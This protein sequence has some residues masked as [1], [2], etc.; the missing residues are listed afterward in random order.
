MA[1]PRMNNISFWLLPPSILLLVLSTLVEQGAGTRSS[2]R[3]ISNYPAKN[4][5]MLEI[6]EKNPQLSGVMF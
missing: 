4:N 1:F 6:P 3:G 2:A 5:C